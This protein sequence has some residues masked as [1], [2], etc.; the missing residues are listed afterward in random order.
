MICQK[1]VCIVSS[2]FKKDI[3]L[4]ILLHTTFAL[5]DQFLDSAHK[6]FLNQTTV[7]LRMEKWIFSNRNL[8]VLQKNTFLYKNP[9]NLEQKSMSGL[10]MKLDKIGHSVL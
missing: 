7:N 8:P 1:L 10:L 5:A 3:N 6:N 4:Q 2:R 9:T